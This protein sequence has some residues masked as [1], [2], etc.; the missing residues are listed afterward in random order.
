MA[1]TSRRKTLWVWVVVVTLFVGAVWV[2]V[3][4]IHSSFQPLSVIKEPFP[5]EANRPEASEHDRGAVN[6]LVFGQVESDNKTL[7]IF[8][9]AQGRRRVEVLNFPAGATVAATLDDVA[10]TVA[11]VEELTG[12]RMDHVLQ[13]DLAS[14]AELDG[15][16]VSSDT[17]VTDP[18][19]LQR[20]DVWASVLTSALDTRD[21][22]QLQAIADTLTPYIAA[23]R[24]LN[25][26]RITELARSVR[27]VPTENISSCTLPKEFSASQQADLAEYFASGQPA[28]C[29]EIF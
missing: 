4:T 18:E 7:S 12:A 20:E 15:A 17:L 11:K 6:F 28:R 16:Q 3:S 23:D 21:P 8:H 27:H 13:W 24:G 22:A 25:T 14:V 1:A 29:A 2:A 26:G 5:D 19:A 10:D 9:L